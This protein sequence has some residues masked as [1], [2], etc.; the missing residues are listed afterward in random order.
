MC[1]CATIALALCALGASAAQAK[2]AWVVK[3]S[4]LAPG[5]ANAKEVRVPHEAVEPF[6]FEVAAA[7][8]LIQCKKAELVGPGGTGKGYIWNEQVGLEVIGR[9]AGILVPVATSCQNINKP[10]CT[11]TA[12]ATLNTSTVSGTLVSNTAGT[13]I[14]DMLVPEGWEEGSPNVLKPF[15]GFTQTTCANA[16]ISANGLAGE[17]VNETVESEIHLIKYL[18]KPACAV[19]PISEVLL[20]NTKKDPISM[21]VGSL[22]AEGCAWVQLELVSGEKWSVK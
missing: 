13:K 11:V 7:H 14:Y 19:A 15:I 9:Q 1:A 3:G 18:G 10:A 21:K 16:V 17:I 22:V 20:S 2:Y 4:Q 12:A 8:E 5:I 6:Q